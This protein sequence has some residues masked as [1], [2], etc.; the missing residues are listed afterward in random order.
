MPVILS[1][2]VLKAMLKDAATKGIVL[3][4]TDSA[5]RG[6]HARASPAGWVVF[7]WLGWQS[8]KRV[9]R[10]KLGEWPAMTIDAARVAALEMRQRVEAG[11]YEADA[12]CA[13]SVEGG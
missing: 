3:E 11:C 1:T 2:A 10:H 6:L 8:N 7:D 4:Q 13:A 5:T 9:Q 12:Q